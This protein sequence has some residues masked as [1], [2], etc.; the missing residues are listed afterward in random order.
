MV[1]GYL[2]SYTKYTGWAKKNDTQMK[3]NKFFVI[4]F[5]PLQFTHITFRHVQFQYLKGFFRQMKD[6]KVMAN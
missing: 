5:L 3:P 2:K 4:W 1:W 6:K